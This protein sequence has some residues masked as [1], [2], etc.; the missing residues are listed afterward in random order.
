MPGSLKAA[1]RPFREMPSRAE[2]AEGL[3]HYIPEYP[4]ISRYLGTD[5]PQF[6]VMISA[7]SRNQITPLSQ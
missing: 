7:G 3:S 6:E 1:Q 4:G 2:I 5:F